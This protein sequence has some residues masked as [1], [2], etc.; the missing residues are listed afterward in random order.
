[1]NEALERLLLL[2]QAA[3]A[4]VSKELIRAT[5][6]GAQ[7]TARQRAQRLTEIRAVLQELRA[8]AVGTE[9]APGAAWE[10]I[11]AA[12]REGS[13]RAD[14]D[15]PEGASTDLGGIHPRAAQELYAALTGRLDDAIMRVG[16]QA[17]DVLRKVALQEILVG[18]LAGRRRKGN[19][20]A[21][22]ENLRSRGI[23]GFTDRAGRLWK[24]S[25][26]AEMVALTTAQEANTTA[27]MQ[28]LAENGIDLVKWMVRPPVGSREPCE[29]CRK[30]DGK[31]YSMTG[32]TEGYPLLEEAPPLHPRCGC[33]LVAYVGALAA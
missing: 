21:I 25:D 11:A 22:A 6:R 31:V 23:E 27:T 13:Q 10:L 5:A 16:R 30:R 4:L 9:T 32:T 17:E 24:L 1:M 26:Y 18:Q 33:L 7:S 19:A 14:R 8:R 3:E 20:K 15:T 28:R 12:Y 29:P 2:F